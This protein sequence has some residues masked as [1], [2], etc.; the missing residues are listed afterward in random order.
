MARPDLFERIQALRSSADSLRSDAPVQAVGR[1]DGVRVDVDGHALTS[2]RGSDYL[3]LAQQFSV[4]SALQDAV[5]REG[6]NGGAAPAAGGR[7][8]LHQALETEAADWLGHPRALLFSSAYLANLA[9][10]QVLLCEDGDVCA[11]DQLNH[12]SLLDATALAG[13]RLRRYPHLDAEGAMRQL[14]HAADG[15]AM[16]ATDAV[17]CI[18]GD[19][20]PLRSL[21]LVA[22]MQQALLC[23]DDTHGIGVLGDGGRG[24]VSA[25]GMGA[26][27]VPLQVFALDAALGGSGA[28]VVGEAALLEHLA[29]TARPYLH[30][31]AL[32]PAL[33][34]AS[35][36]ALRLARRDDWR[37]EKLVE[38]VGLFRS[39]AR[40]HG[41]GLMA[42]ETPIQS[43]SFATDQQAIALAQNLQ[44]A[45]MW[46]GTVPARLTGDGAARLRV[47]LSALHVPAQVQALVDAIARARD[48]LHAGTL[49][50]AAALA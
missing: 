9:V 21:S 35:L 26:A 8:A 31:P 36:E 3:G 4:V 34:A 22:R 2:F 16:L 6:V 38:L 15:A 27:D 49:L 23:V 44:Q 42:A 50:S 5:A 20:A 29:A 14:K 12:P 41:L 33:A 25:A 40:G 39:A 1:R 17:F 10:Q 11:Q 13:A 43:L 47:S 28:L 24:S 19:S 30:S 7:H 48:G 18:D 45:G 32:S 46:V 37:R